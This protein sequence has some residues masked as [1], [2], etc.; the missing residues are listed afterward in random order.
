MAES[1]AVGRARGK[2][3]VYREGKGGERR[4]GAWEVEKRGKKGG[5]GM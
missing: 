3:R 4:G 2:E 5:K 1:E